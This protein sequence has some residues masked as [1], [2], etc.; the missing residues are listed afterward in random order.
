MNFSS[1]STLTKVT[2]KIN[3]R[4]KY[5]TLRICEH[6]TFSANVTFVVH[7]TIFYLFFPNRFIYLKI[8]ININIHYRYS[9]FIWNIYRN[10]LNRLIYIFK[11]IEDSIIFQYRSFITSISLITMIK[12]TC[13]WNIWYLKL[14]KRLYMCM[15]SRRQALLIE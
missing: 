1:H 13:I 7:S 15:R 2:Y 10:I 4:T 12:F 14:V 11:Y 3:F 9:Y 8:E 6:W 5:A